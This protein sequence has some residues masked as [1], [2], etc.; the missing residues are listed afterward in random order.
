MKYCPYCG[1]VLV[2]GAVSFCAECG[3]ALPETEKKE[4]IHEP[5]NPPKQKTES[6]GARRPV[7]KDDYDGYY[8]DILPID[9]GRFSEGID[10]MMIK[11]ILFIIG[12]VLLI[13][14]ACIVMMYLL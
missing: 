10:R 3:K 14:G 9:E 11:K 4:E 2:N 8:D 6:L 12:M 5:P 1:A 13:V 7:P